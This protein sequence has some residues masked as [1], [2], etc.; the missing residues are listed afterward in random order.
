MKTIKLSY[1]ILDA[2][3]RGD[4]ERA[5]SYY[6]GDPIPPTDAMKLGAMKHK[7]WERHTKSF[8]TLHDDFDGGKLQRPITE[9][10]YEKIIPLS[11]DYRILIRG[12]VDLEHIEDNVVVIEDYKCGKTPASDYVDGFQLSY[13]KLLRP[14]AERGVYR[15]FNPYTEEVTKGIRF[16]DERDARE[17]LEH[18]ITHGGEMIQYLESQRLV[19]DYRGKSK[20]K[21]RGK[22]QPR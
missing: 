13:Y 12:V 21:K 14:R 16:L 6:L 1:S 17:A 19:R 20:K 11:D 15:C 10:K 8:G 9:K 22:I 2:W 3:A 18:I 4:Y 7:Q 5:V